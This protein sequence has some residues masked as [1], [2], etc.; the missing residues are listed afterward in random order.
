MKRIYTY[1]MLA[2]GLLMSSCQE[3]FIDSQPEL[4]PTL[5]IDALDEYTVVAAS[6]SRIV[7]NISSNTP[8]KIETDSQWC[9]P[10]P[11]MSASSSLVAEIVITPEDNETEYS[12]TATLTVTADEIGV[13]KTIKVLQN[14]MKEQILLVLADDPAENTITA[15]DGT[16]GESL[17]N[18]NSNKP[19]MIS[20]TDL[21]EWLKVSKEGEGQIKVNVTANN[22]LSERNALIKLTAQGTEETAEFTFKIV[23]PSPVIVADGAKLSVDAMTGYTKVEFTKGEMFRTAYTIAKGRT[24][25]ELDD[26]KMSSI[27]NLGFNFTAASGANYKLH[28]EGDN[29]YWY[30]CAGGFSWVAPIKKKYTLDEVN[31]IRKLEFVVENDTASPGK[32]MI[33]IYINDVLYG[34]Q[35]GRTDI[36]ATGDPGCHFIFEAGNDPTPGDYCVFKSITYLTE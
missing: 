19:W 25:I 24:V 20:S 12:R 27:Y 32:L 10:E 18:I 23:Q 11:A 14:K 2:A 17:V 29:T 35:T 21:P 33:S 16:Q 36:F 15:G 34:T 26:M 28:M 30:R 1:I 31:A 13:V 3:Y 7:F 4:P 8:W 9:I 6:P 22:T 5:Y